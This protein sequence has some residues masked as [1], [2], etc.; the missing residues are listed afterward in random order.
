MLIIIA[1]ANNY[2]CVA[3]NK[4]IHIQKLHAG[5][6][7]TMVQCTVTWFKVYLL[8][9]HVHYNV[10]LGNCLAF[11]SNIIIMRLLYISLLVHGNNNSCKKCEK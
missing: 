11:P 6:L 9:I 10:Q 5:V 8:Y 2:V 1:H 3:E 4:I 7:Y